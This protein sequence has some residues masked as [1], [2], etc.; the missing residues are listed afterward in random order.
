MINFENKSIVSISDLTRKEIFICH[1]TRQRAK[2]QTA[3]KIAGRQNYG[4]LF[5]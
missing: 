2:K 5:F 1:Q 3:A 4:Q